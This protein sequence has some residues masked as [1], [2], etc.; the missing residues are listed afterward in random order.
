MKLLSILAL[1]A[2]LAALPAF[3]QGPPK[4]WTGEGVFGAGATT[5]NTETRDYT[6]GVRGKHTGSFWSQSG[7]LTADYG[8]IDHIAS[9]QRYTAALQTDFQFGEHASAFGRLTW[10]RDEFSG[11]DTRYFLGAGLAWKVLSGETTQWTVQGGPGY[12]IDD[13][14]ATLAVAAASEESFGASAG[15]R[16]KHAFN[17]NVALTND[18]DVIYAAASTQYKNALALTFNIMGNLSARISYDIRH[19]TDPLPRFKAD[20]TTSKFSLVYKIG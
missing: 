20:D 14:R 8:E 11:F 15:S 7:E 5:G 17:P 6:V 13:I 12:R 1:A 18:T 3:A 2:P 4:T 9:R 10:E 19:E 16:L